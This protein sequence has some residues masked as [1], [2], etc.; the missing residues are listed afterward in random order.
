M[1]KI[2]DMLCDTV[3]RRIF[4]NFG[5]ASKTRSVRKL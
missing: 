1:E 4:Q 5:D 2:E 3:L